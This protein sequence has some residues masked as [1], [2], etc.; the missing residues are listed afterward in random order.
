[1]DFPLPKLDEVI[2]LLKGAR[3]FASADN[4]K[5]YWQFPI[6]DASK[7]YTGFVC[8][9]GSYEHNRVPMGLKIAAAY[10]QRT[11]QRVL[12]GLLYS[13]ILQYIDDTLIYAQNE[14][15]LLDVL[16][17]YFKTISAY[18]IKLHPGKFVL[19]D[20]KLVWG[21]KLVSA[22][23]TRPNPKKVESILAMGE[24][25]D[26]SELMNFVYGVVWF[27][28]PLYDTINEA[29]SKYKKKT[30]VNA[31]KVKLSNLPSWK[32]GRKAFQAVKEALADAVTTAYFDPDKKL[33]VF[34]DA[35]DEYWCIMLTLCEPGVEKLPWEE[36]TRRH[37]LLALES[38]RFRHAQL[39]WHTVD[40]EGFSFGVK[41]RDYA[42]W[43]LGS[44]HVTALFTD[45]RNLLAFFADEARPVSCTKPNRDRLTRWGLQLAGLK[46]A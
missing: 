12:E 27:R 41:L 21:G 38:G 19:Y 43:I 22:M 32:E 46:Y 15:E 16:E 17:T 28:G 18:N 8:P 24:P 36:Q 33:C 2:H 44:R 26:A 25:T 1:M 42:H 20:T 7:R 14:D 11:I 31:R 3:C 5:G 6:S 35:S 40:K 37:Q 29:L 34:A 30:S 13:H 9:I 4:T 39:R 45:H 10:Y 23:G